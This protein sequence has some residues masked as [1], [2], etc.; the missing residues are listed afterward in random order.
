MRNNLI[1]E[2]KLYFDIREL[3]CQDVWNKFK[4]NSWQFLS[5][6]LL[7]TLL[8]LRKVIFNKP[9]I[10]NTWHKGGQF[11]Q[12]G[13]RCNMC[14]LVNNKK[15]VYVSAHIL[16]KAIDFNVLGLSTETVYELIRENINK[17]EYPIRIEITSGDWNHIDVYQPYNSNKKLIEFKS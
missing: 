3:I 10:V 4:E 15:S 11:S 16:G 13:L 8:I 6:E 17:F 9:I 12:R 2:L 14:A 1:K 5:T 7:S